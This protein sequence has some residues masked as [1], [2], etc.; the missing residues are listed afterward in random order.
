[1]LILV[2]ATC[3]ATGFTNR[4][5]G[6]HFIRSLAV[7][8]L[9]TGLSLPFRQEAVD[10]PQWEASNQAILNEQEA[11][12]PIQFLIYYNSTKDRA[13]RTFGPSIA[14]NS[15]STQELTEI[16]HRETSFSLDEDFIKQNE[17]SPE[18]RKTLLI[19]R[20]MRVFYALEALEQ[21]NR[22]DASELLLEVFATNIPKDISKESAVKKSGFVLGITP[23]HRPAILLAM[24]QS[25]KK[26]VFG[27]DLEAVEPLKITINTDD[28]LYVS[29]VVGSA[30]LHIPLKLLDGF[31]FRN[32]VAVG[33]D[34]I[35]ALMDE[36]IGCRANLFAVHF[37]QGGKGRP[38]VPSASLSQYNPRSGDQLFESLATSERDSMYD[39]WLHAQLPN[40]G[41]KSSPLK[42][43][44]AWSLTNN[45]D[46]KNHEGNSSKGSP[47]TTG[48]PSP[49]QIPSNSK[50]KSEPPYQETNP[51]YIYWPPEKPSDSQANPSQG[52]PDSEPNLQDP[53]NPGSQEG[54]NQPQVETQEPPYVGEDLVWFLKEKF[55]PLKV[56]LEIGGSKLSGLALTIHLASGSELGHKDA[57]WEHDPELL[58]LEISRTLNDPYIRKNLG[59]IGFNGHIWIT[60]HYER[61]FTALD[62]PLIRLHEP[63]GTLYNSLDRLIRN[64]QTKDNGPIALIVRLPG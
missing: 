2:L 12:V 28:V 49:R 15:K 20:L 40:G 46:D 1:M 26:M 27:K 29:I 33:G 55:N 54:A 19:I 56:T 18:L 31:Q 37:K 59:L 8:A 42:M 41:T 53:L 11:L 17:H 3:F 62:Y 13:I 61:D 63:E 24:A 57:R 39:H 43:P 4:S 45:H 51:A 9:T 48:N 35:I 7:G 36:C 64:A 60:A 6:E 21:S 22:P 52:Q 50:K 30:K 47:W 23:L 34:T 44:A 16:L 38:A 5:M 10:A 25:D 58:L 14:A 32:P